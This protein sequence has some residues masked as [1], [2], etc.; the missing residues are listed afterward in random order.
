MHLHTGDQPIIFFFRDAVGHVGNVFQYAAADDPD[1]S[2]AGMDG[3]D[4]FENMQLVGDARPPHLENRGEKLMRNGQVIRIE[5]VMAHQQPACEPFPQ[6]ILSVCKHKL[7][8]LKQ[9]D[10]DIAQQKHT[11]ARI[12]LHFPSYV[13]SRNQEATAAH[14]HDGFI[15][16]GF[17]AQKNGPAGNP[18][19]PDQHSFNAFAAVIMNNGRCETG[20]DKTEMG[21]GLAS[22]NELVSRRQMSSRTV[23]ESGMTTISAGATPWPEARM[24]TA[25][26]PGNEEDLKGRPFVGPAG[27]LL[28]QCLEAGIDRSQC[29]VTNAVKHFKFEQRGKRRIHA[30]PNGGEV[31]HCAW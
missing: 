13:S 19:P 28:H 7:A 5:T 20:F 22:R 30:R 4:A 3:M 8:D 21:N 15:R 12:F 23:T 14:A 27:R 10:I 16:R 18:F 25:R 31:Q 29:Y 26:Q 6:T 2:A 24:E 1:V 11:Q 9:A 17:R